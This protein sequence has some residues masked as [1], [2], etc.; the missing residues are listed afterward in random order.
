[1]KPMRVLAVAAVLALA[2]AGCSDGKGGD[3]NDPSSSGAESLPMLHGFVFDPALRPLAGATVKVLDTNASTASDD[4]GFFGFDGLPIEQFLV[5]VAT[6]DGFTPSSKQITLAQDAPVRM[7]FTLEPIPVA[8]PYSNVLKQEMMLECQVATVIQDQTQTTDCGSGTQEIDTFDIA[9]DAGLAGAVV[10]VYWD[11]TTQMAESLGAKLET[12]EL[13]QLNLVL[14]Q[15]VGT[16]PLIIRVPQS[17]AERYYPSGGLMRLTLYAE[18]NVDENEAGTGA[19]VAFQQVA[20]A[21]ASLFYVAPP[22][23]TYTLGDQG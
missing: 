7:N 20:S 1:M 11:P 6:M 5:V 12:L 9:V 17:T 3:G 15:V 4:E 10:E 22:D 14:G 18:P 2:L 13:G 8:T 16:S 21:Y 19:A 23:P